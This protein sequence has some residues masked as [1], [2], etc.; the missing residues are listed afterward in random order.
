M[1]SME[2]GSTQTDRLGWL[3]YDLHT[4]RRATCFWWEPFMEKK[5]CVSY[6]IDIDPHQLQLHENA[7]ATPGRRSCLAYSF[8]LPRRSQLYLLCDLKSGV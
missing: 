5:V 8:S 6:M 4:S 1:K 2:T 3:T 7:I